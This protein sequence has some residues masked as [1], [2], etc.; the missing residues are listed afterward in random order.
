MRSDTHDEYK[1]K[2]ILLHCQHVKTNTFL[3][4][5]VKN[6]A[7]AG[8]HFDG[9]EVDCTTFTTAANRTTHGTSY[10]AG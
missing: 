10:P 5:L 8:H 1:Q 6:V 9:I 4:L 7:D 2:K 3:K